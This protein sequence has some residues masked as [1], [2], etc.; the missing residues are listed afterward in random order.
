MANGSEREVD[1]GD[2]HPIPEVR[3][4]HDATTHDALRDDPSDKES[5][6]DIAS[7]ESFPASDPPSHTAPG[8]SEPAP[9]SGYDEDAERALVEQGGDRAGTVADEAEPLAYGAVHNGGGF[10]GGESPR[11]ADADASEERHP[12]DAR[13][14]FGGDGAQYSAPDEPRPDM[15]PEA[16]A[17]RHAVGPGDDGYDDQASKPMSLDID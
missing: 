14:H 7:D 15:S 8:G 16:Q 6:V 13:T 12:H 4:A 2:A 17:R 9:S 5:V 11:D 3:E 1:Q 10:T